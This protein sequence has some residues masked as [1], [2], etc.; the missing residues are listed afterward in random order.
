MI[1]KREEEG[2]KK[3]RKRKKKSSSNS[4][5]HCHHYHQAEGHALVIPPLP[6]GRVAHACNPTIWERKTDHASPKEALKKKKTKNRKRNQ[7][8]RWLWFPLTVHT[9]TCSLAV[10]VASC[11]CD[12]KTRSKE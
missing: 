8:R 4:Y 2:E 10:L 6:P 11:C 3:E 12:N 7:G 9:G 1:K 5:P